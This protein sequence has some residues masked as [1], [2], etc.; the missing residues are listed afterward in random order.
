M[1]QDQHSQDRTRQGGRCQLF[2]V[3][4]VKGWAMKPLKKD[5]L[6]GMFWRLDMREILVNAAS[7]IGASAH[8]RKLRHVVLIVIRKGTVTASRKRLSR[9]SETPH[10][11]RS[12][13]TDRRIRKIRVYGMTVSGNAAEALSI[14]WSPG[15]SHSW[16]PKS[17]AVVPSSRSR[18]MAERS[19][20]EL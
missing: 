10:G 18:A 6:E 5:I 3:L 12:M 19:Y 15:S 11:G 17:I 14:W 4:A 8:F 7:H 1:Q 2:A 20:R 13:P 16:N 9:N